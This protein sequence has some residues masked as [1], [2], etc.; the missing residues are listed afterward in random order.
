MEN[1]DC[2][3]VKRCPVVLKTLEE[4]SR[5]GSDLRFILFSP[6]RL[7]G[8]WLPDRAQLEFN[9]KGVEFSDKSGAATASNTVA[10]DTSY[11]D[12]G[13]VDDGDDTASTSD[14]ESAPEDLGLLRE[15]HV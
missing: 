9:E 8:S 10:D 14:E 6:N 15:L 2:W 7:F 1:L 3:G 13:A 11:Y 12:E 5:D 4:M